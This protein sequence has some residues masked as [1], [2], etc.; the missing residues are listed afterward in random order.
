MFSIVHCSLRNAAPRIAKDDFRRFVPLVK[1]PLKLNRL[2]PD[3]DD[4]L[5]FVAL[6]FG[7]VGVCGC[8]LVCLFASLTI[9]DQI[10]TMSHVVDQWMAGDTSCDAPR[11]Q[12]NAA[13]AVLGPFARQRVG[14]DIN[15][16]LRGRGVSLK[17][18]RAVL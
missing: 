2:L 12:A 9:T 1:K 14:H 10:I 18:R 11:R 13:D 15:P 6:L 17:G 7:V 16:G 4:V 8:A 3:P 5:R